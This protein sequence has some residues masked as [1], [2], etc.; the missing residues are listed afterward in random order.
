M[1]VAAPGAFAGLG[2]RRR[3]GRAGRRDGI[4]RYPGADCRVTEAGEGHRPGHGRDGRRRSTC[5]SRRSTSRS[6]RSAGCRSGRGDRAPAGSIWRI[7]DIGP[8]IYDSPG[9]G[10][11]SE[12]Q[13]RTRRK[14]V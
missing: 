6:C 11:R 8:E 2:S 7:L 12:V 5:R 14:T 9:C 13:Q 10:P 1:A 3:P 4:V